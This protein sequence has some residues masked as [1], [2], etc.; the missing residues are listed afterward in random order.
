[1]SVFGDR[2]NAFEARFV[3]DAAK[4]FK[5]EASRNKALGH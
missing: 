4:E 3:L 2:K 1:M 5:A